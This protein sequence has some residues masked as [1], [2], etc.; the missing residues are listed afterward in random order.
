MRNLSMILIVFIMFTSC[1]NDEKSNAVDLQKTTVEST[2]ELTG[3]FMY[4]DDVAVFQ[5]STDLYGVH[6][7]EKLME[8]VEQSQKFKTEAFDGVGANLKVKVF[9]KPAHEE[10]WENRIE[11]FEIL[12]VFKANPNNQQIIKLETNS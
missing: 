3:N 7:N 8:L 10:G 2:V 1:K 12:K 6:Q 9:K 4:Y 11:I 5:T